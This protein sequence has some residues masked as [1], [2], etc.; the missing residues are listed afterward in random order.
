M[1]VHQKFRFGLAEISILVSG[2][3]DDM[4]ATVS[5]CNAPTEFECVVLF[6][7]EQDHFCLL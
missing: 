2:L 5:E 6:G 1:N 4:H 3:T 7:V